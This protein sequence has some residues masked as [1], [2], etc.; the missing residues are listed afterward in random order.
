MATKQEVLDA[1]AEEKAQIIAKLDELNAQIQA[2]QDQI[3]AGT[4]VT[5]AD[6]DEIKGA[7]NDIFVP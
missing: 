3:N 1:I 4:P 7:V 5:A 6:L 2:L